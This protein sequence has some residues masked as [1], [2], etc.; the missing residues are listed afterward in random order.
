MEPALS[1]TPG[2]PNSPPTANGTPAADARDGL[3]PA[4]I[5]KSFVEHVEFT[6]GAKRILVSA[7]VAH[8]GADRAHDQA[9]QE[10]QPGGER[11]GHAE[12]EQLIL[13]LRQRCERKHGQSDAVTCGC[14]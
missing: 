8:R 14:G 2:K 9:R 7:G 13:A 4:E 11:L 3:K 6:R 1:P 10:R 12:A 5:R